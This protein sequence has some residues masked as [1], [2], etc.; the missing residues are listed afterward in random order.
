M[1]TNNWNIEKAM[2]SV[3][4]ARPFYSCRELEKIT[5]NENTLSYGLIF[6][7]NLIKGENNKY[8]PLFERLKHEL[9]S[10][11]DLNQLKNLAFNI[12]EQNLIEIAQKKHPFHIP[13][14]K[15]LNFN[16]EYLK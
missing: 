1:C 2:L 16:E 10:Y 15:L 5:I 4:Q 13:D 14:S 7:A 6:L 9:K 11:N 12:S 3:I 8:L